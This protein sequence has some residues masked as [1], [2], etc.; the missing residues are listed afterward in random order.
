[1]VDLR[2]LGGG[3]TAF[4]D[5]FEWVREHASD[6]RAVVYLTDLV[7]HDFG[8]EPDCPVLWAVPGDPRQFEHVSGRTP[9]GEAI[10]LQA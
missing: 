8:D 10:Y 4:A 5:T 6:A 1:V 7:V 2:M 3:G 9:F